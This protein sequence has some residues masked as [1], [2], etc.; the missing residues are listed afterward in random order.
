M[1][2]TGYIFFSTVGIAIILLVGGFFARWLKYKVLISIY[3]GYEEYR[4]YNIP[5]N[6]VYLTQIIIGTD[7]I[8]ASLNTHGGV[9]QVTMP[10]TYSLQEVYFEIAKRLDEKAKEENQ[11]SMCLI[12]NNVIVWEQNGVARQQAQCD[13]SSLDSSG[14]CH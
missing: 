13:S 2:I 6:A 5:K 12:V 1:T 10:V 4:C 11:D 7:K 9:W 3:R 8:V 14:L